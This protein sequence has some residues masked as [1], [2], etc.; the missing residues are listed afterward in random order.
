MG[1]GGRVGEGWSDRKHL[2]LQNLK[3]A[4]AKGQLGYQEAPGGPL[5]KRSRPLKGP[6]SWLPP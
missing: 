4:N 1:G 5:V 6:P 3:T 2:H